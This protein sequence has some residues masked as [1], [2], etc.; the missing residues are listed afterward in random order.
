MQLTIREAIPADYWAIHSLIANE[1]GYDQTDYNKLCAR[2][3]LMNAD[4]NLSTIVAV[5]EEKVVGFVGLRKG[6]AYN[7][8]GEY[9]QVTAL[10]VRKEL[11]NK[12]IGSRL[13]KWTE[14]YALSI[15]IHNIVLTSR[16]HRT[17]AHAFYES[18]GYVKKSYGYKKDL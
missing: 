6:L 7:I 2:L 8:D 1:L 3:D 18:N 14:N 16:L 10:A 9:M 12:G 5:A 17:G 4:T 13:M 11:Q 15:G